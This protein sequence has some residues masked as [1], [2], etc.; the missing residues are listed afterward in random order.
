MLRKFIRSHAF[1]ARRWFSETTEVT[2]Q[3]PAFDADA[4]NPENYRDLNQKIKF[5]TGYAL[6][7]VEPFPRLK[8]ME[9]GL[10]L[11]KKI[12][13]DL[14]ESSYARMFLEERV[15]YIMEVTHETPNIQLLEKKLGIDCIELFIETFADEYNGIEG[16]KEAKPWIDNN[17][18]EDLAMYEML[19]VP[20]DQQIR[21]QSLPP[22]Q[23]P[24][25][26]RK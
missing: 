13:Q 19:K 3:K 14:P 26:L 9:I 12:R 24:H 4:V 22:D 25:L 10:T 6:M 15:K 17:T 11:L 23:K 7:E 5:K 1:V 16:L 2:Q 18:P 21:F 8:I 20:Y